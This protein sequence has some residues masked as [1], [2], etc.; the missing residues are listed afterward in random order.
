MKPPY[1]YAD[2]PRLPAVG[3]IQTSALT[4]QQHGKVEIEIGPGRGAFLIDRAKE[5]PEAR[6]IGFEIRWKWATLVD[7]RLSALGLGA[8]ARVY[9]EDARLVL[10]RL[11][12]SGGVAAVFI[13][14]PDPWWKTRQRKRLV[15]GAPLL[16]AIARLLSPGGMLFMQTDVVERAESYEAL[17]AAHGA[18]RLAGDA[19][20][21]ARVREMPWSARG[22]RERR[23]LADGIP[24]TR[25]RFRR[26]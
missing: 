13:H 25:L 10:T 11:E 17:A 20:S 26:V 12:P 19:P 18:F 15:V 2:A 23:A 5:E 4:E 21:T 6:V 3:P 7:R 9:A 1:P 16:D 24:I 8:R 14:F 22:N